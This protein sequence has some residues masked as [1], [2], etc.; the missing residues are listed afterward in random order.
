VTGA[1]AMRECG[2][3]A[4]ERPQRGFKPRLFDDGLTLEVR[5]LGAWEA[6][7]AEGQSACPVCGGSMAA[8]SGCSDCGAELS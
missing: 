4:V 1:L 6:L 8:E 3:A 7:V 2:T 5:I